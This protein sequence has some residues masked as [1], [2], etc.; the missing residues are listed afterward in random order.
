LMEVNG[1]F[2]GSQPLATASGAH[3]A[4]EMYRQRLLGD[5]QPAPPYRENVQAR[6]M[7]PEIKRL[8]RLFLQF[9]KVD[10]MAYKAT[11][12]RDFYRLIVDF[13]RPNSHYYVLVADDPKPFFADMRSIF[14]KALRRDK[15]PQDDPPPLLSVQN[16]D[17]NKRVKE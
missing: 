6:F 16:I 15:A 8:V 13:W 11:K 7:V 4:W 1:R 2:W 14:R 12:W 5:D 9:R 17:G 10:T 3:F